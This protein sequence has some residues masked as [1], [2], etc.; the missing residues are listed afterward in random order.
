MIRGT[1]R[2]LLRPDEIG[3]VTPYADQVRLL[4]KLFD[5]RGGR[6]Q[7]CKYEGLEIRSV[8][9]YQGREK[10]VIIFSSVRSNAG[11]GIGFLSDRRRINVAI[12]RARRGLVVLGHR[13]TLMRDRKATWKNWLRFVD[14]HEIEVPL[15]LLYTYMG[16]PIPTSCG[17]ESLRAE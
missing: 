14:E 9:G 12:T 2:R 4:R 1:P 6:R 11:G 16:R 5:R 17:G 8:D 10:E 7:N 3:I 15:D 13:D